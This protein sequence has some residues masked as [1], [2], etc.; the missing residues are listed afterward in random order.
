MKALFLFR[1]R[2]GIYLS[3]ITLAT[4]VGCSCAWVTPE[5]FCRSILE[6][7]HVIWE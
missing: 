4:T 1:L 3:I 5:H 2:L 7:N 6:T